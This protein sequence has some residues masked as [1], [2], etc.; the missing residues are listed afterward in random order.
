MIKI[1]ITG[2]IGS[3]KSTIS[4]I[5]ELLGVPV[6]YADAEAKELM[7][8][9]SIVKSAI[10][11]LFGK[12]VIAEKETLDR[13]AI[14]AIVFNDKNKLEKL[15]AIIHPTIASHFNNWLIKQSNAVYILKEA[16]ILF[17]SGAN[18]QMD[19]VIVVTAPQQL[20]ID[21]VLLRDKTSREEVEHRINNQLPDEELVKLANYTITNDETQMVI[22]QLLAIHKR[23]TG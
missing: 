8:T 17:E 2:G 10:I 3:G 5:F 13:K 23:I 1:G 15:N 6:Y 19:K 14:S 11:D 21:R 18:K 20:R 16:A 22:N 4:R 12:N 7:N 9:D